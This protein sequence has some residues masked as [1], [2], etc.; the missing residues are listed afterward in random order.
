MSD[1]HGT[2]RRPTGS[3]D[4][5]G[6]ALPEGLDRRRLAQEIAVLNRELRRQGVR[7]VLP[8]P[9]DS[10]GGSR[11]RDRLA[12]LLMAALRE[13]SDRRV[14]ALLYR[15]TARH[16]LGFCRSR[17]QRFR[18]TRR[19]AHGID[20]ADIVEETFVCVFLHRHTFRM[21]ARASFV[22]WSFVIA[23]NLMRQ[24]ARRGAERGEIALPADL[25]A[26][27][28]E[29]PFQEAVG[30]EI[31]ASYE[32]GLEMFVRLC[33]AALIGLPPR[34]RRALE[35]RDGEGLTYQQ[36]AR[37]MEVR[38]GHVGMLVRRARKRILGEV[39]RVLSRWSGDS[40]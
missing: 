5:F 19:S 30:R 2:E 34:W 28:G 36:I 16:L 10:T 20:P 9:T 14:F 32:Q 38:T 21:T 22:G 27:P 24:A 26:C 13:S 17:I 7:I 39:G 12:T 35:L 6:L 29:G 25:L 31:L 4:R 23:E 11:D 15:L 3:E 18:R 40:R 37:R 33:A 8:V 1:R